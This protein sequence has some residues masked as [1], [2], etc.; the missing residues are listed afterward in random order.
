MSQYS[1]LLNEKLSANGIVNLDSPKYDW[2]LDLE[3]CGAFF[4]KYF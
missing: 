4:E 1:V 2:Q 3:I